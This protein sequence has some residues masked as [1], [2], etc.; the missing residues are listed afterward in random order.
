AFVLPPTRP[1]DGPAGWWYVERVQRARAEIHPVDAARESQVVVARGIRKNGEMVGEALEAGGWPRAR[2]GEPARTKRADGPF[3]EFVIT[4]E[5]ALL[6]DIPPVFVR[7]LGVVSVFHKAP[8]AAAV[9]PAHGEIHAAMPGFRG[10]H[11]HQG[12]E[13]EVLTL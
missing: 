12:V 11:F 2:R 5:P 10:L 1:E 6:R 4:H 13:V 9:A 7:R 8:I 3:R